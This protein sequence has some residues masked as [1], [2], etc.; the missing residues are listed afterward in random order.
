MKLKNPVEVE[1]QKVMG[2]IAASDA[3]RLY[4][5]PSHLVCGL[6]FPMELKNLVEVELQK[7]GLLRRW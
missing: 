4:A 1:L 5:Q 3:R 6:W 7:V 2:S